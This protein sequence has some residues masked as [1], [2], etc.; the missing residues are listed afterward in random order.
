M[1]NV[2]HLSWEYPP[3]TVGDLSRRL[4]DLLPALNSLVSISLVVRADR[5]GMTQIDG[6]KVYKVGTS[7]RT[8]PNYIAYAQVLNIELTR[9][10]SDAIHSDPG[11]AIVHAHDWISS[12]AG[13]YL[14]SHF[15]MPLIISIY[16]TEAMRSRPPLNVVNRGI[17]DLERYCFQ[18][19]EALI[20]ENEGMKSHL[21]EQYK[22]PGRVEVCSSPEQVHGIYRRWLG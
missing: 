16:S 15:R 22:L 6:M 11:I 8:S 20:V 13:T 3:W 4:K 12:I 18:E 7:V 14:A 9:G 2:I 10:G 5:D 21:A 1:S 17:Y 19:A